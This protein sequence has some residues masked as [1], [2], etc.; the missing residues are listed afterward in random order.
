MHE[1]PFNIVEH[2]YLVDSIKSLRPSF[3]LKSRV[4]IRKEIMEKNFGRKG[5][6]VQILEN[7]AMPL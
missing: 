1:Y 7:Y 4:T 2:E 6:I 3:P 5:N